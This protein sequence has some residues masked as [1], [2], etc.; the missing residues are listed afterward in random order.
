MYANASDIIYFVSLTRALPCKLQRLPALTASRHRATVGRSQV[1]C[2]RC[3]FYGWPYG[4]RRRQ[5]LNHWTRRWGKSVKKY[6]GGSAV[7]GVALRLAASSV[8]LAP[9]PPA[10]Q[11]DGTVNCQLSRAYI[12]REE[13][14]FRGVATNKKKVNKI[15]IEIINLWF[16]L[17]ALISE[18]YNNIDWSTYFTFIVLPA[19]SRTILYWSKVYKF[20]KRQLV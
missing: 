7:A 5:P 1:P 20:V 10:D 16:L 17:Y 11:S 4:V 6:S 9:R 14:F 19:W 18:C 15:K 13:N 3:I 8:S 12:D 2:S